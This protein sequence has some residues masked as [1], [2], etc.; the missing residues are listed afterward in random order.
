MGNVQW[1]GA[2]D[3]WVSYS[4]CIEP[5]AAST[6][7]W[8]FNGQV[9]QTLNPASGASPPF[10]MNTKIGEYGQVIFVNNGDQNYV[11]AYEWPQIRGKWTNVVIQMNFDP[12]GVQGKINIWF[13]GTQV[14][15]YAGITGQTPSGGGTQNYYWKFGVYRGQSPEYQA[16]RYA[17]MTYS[18]S[19]LAAKIA[20]PDA[21][22]AGY[23]TT[24]Q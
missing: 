10:A 5:G 17:N 15:N 21:I 14:V 7:N 1:A 3:A 11:T 20:S 9:H 4:V 12:T 19:S 2:T 24:C 13:D 16:V 8:F 22:P 18:S 23:G 6:G